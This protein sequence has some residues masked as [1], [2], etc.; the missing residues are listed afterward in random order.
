MLYVVVLHN[1][2]CNWEESVTPNIYETFVYLQ[3]LQLKLNSCL[4]I[5]I[6]PIFYQPLLLQLTATVLPFLPLPEP[7]RQ[8]GT[9]LP[10]WNTPI[11]SPTVMYRLTGERERHT[12][13]CMVTT[14]YTIKCP[15][16]VLLILVMWCVTRSCYVVLRE[17]RGKTWGNLQRLWLRSCRLHLWKFY[18]L[19]HQF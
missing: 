2:V 9:V 19:F 17:S 12:C 3:R 11:T 1:V 4:T 8:A 13:R 18:R 15:R 5:A 10:R 14:W 7:E 16:L 6:Y